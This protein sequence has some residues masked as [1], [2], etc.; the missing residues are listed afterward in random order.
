[1]RPVTV[2]GF[3]PTL[4]TFL[5]GICPALRMLVAILYAAWTND[6]VGKAKAKGLLLFSYGIAP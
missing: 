3:L 5:F 4:E 2:N 1:M 6:E